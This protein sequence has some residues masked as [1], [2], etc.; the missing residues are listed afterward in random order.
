MYN[1]KLRDMYCKAK[2][3][4]VCECKNLHYLDLRGSL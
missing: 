2:V 3:K 1:D 4:R